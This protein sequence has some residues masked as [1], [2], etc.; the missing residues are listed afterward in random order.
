[1]LPGRI[2]PLVLP[3]TQVIGCCVSLD[4]QRIQSLDSS[5]KQEA[6]GSQIESQREAAGLGLCCK[7]A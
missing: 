4:K 1:M 2:S 3:H 7:A 5:S 6:H